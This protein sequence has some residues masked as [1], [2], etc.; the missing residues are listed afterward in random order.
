MLADGKEILAD[1][2]QVNAG[3]LVVTHMGN[4]IPF[5][6]IVVKRARNG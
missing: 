1:A 6:G 2:N 3:D 5:D 4:L